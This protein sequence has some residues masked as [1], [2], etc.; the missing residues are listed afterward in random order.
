MR[1]WCVVGFAA[2]VFLWV[3]TGPPRLE[4]ARAGS[5]GGEVCNG[6]SSH[7]MPEKGRETV[8]DYEGVAF[9]LAEGNDILTQRC[10]VTF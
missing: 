5:L 7:S 9:G 6:Y 3:P 1:S 8:F 4:R 2:E 10:D